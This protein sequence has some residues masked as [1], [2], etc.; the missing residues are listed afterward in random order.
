MTVQ[1]L[2]YQERINLVLRHIEN[3]L[4]KPPSLE[5]LSGIACFSSYHF[6]RIFSA[7]VGE[8]VAAYIRRLLL[9]RA[10][11]RLLY[12]DKTIT[13]VALD[14][15]YD[16]IDA[17]TRAFR[18]LFGI[19]PS[20][21]RRSDG[22]LTHAQNRQT[23]E[24]LFYHLLPGVAPMDV[25]IRTFSPILVAAIRYVGPYDDCGSV[26]QKLCGAL[27]AHRL[28]R[29]KLLVGYCVCHDNPDVAPL[30]KCR[31]E[32][33]LPLPKDITAEA[34]EVVQ[35]L[36]D[37]EIY[38]RNI[39]GDGEYAA[40]QVKGPYTLIHKAYRSMFSEWL[41]QSGREPGGSLGF[42]AYYNSPETTPPEEL[43]MEIFIPL[44]PR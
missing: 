6:H 17:F 21:Y 35:L 22:P 5:E 11:N 18:S 44:L 36:E 7:M 32:I 41:P 20:A 43:L 19:L 13:E 4:D 14:A 10:A 25:Q 38:L 28:I 15:G 9:Q 3:N 24:P 16:S 1:Y 30:E 23:G 26:W 34:P 40:M 2:S 29:E 27:A 8:S 37:K 33:C 42:E 31:M 39:G 12:A